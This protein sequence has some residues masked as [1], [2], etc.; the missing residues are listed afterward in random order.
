[1]RFAEVDCT[2]TAYS[3]ELNAQSQVRNE[4]RFKKDFAR[5]TLMKTFTESSIV[6]WCLAAGLGDLFHL[7]NMT[8][9]IHSMRSAIE[10]CSAS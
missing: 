9:E 1:L 2:A 7:I 4:H 6:G 8:V 10:T 3:S 5:G